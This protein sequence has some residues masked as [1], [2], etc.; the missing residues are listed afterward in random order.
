MIW[1]GLRISRWFYQA[2]ID[3]KQSRTLAEEI[4]GQAE[5][6]A[7]LDPDYI[8]NLHKTALT[9]RRVLQQAQGE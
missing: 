5:M 1:R 6:I 2:E 8:G 3:S 7:P 4:G 9:F